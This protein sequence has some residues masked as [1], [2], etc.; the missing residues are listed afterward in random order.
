M[1]MIMFDFSK[2]IGMSFGIDKCKVLNIVRGK[3]QKNGDVELPD[4]KII[5]E[6]EVDEIYKY[7]GV[8]ESIV[9]KHA[10]MKEK[11]IGVFKK[12]L[13]SILRTELN[14]KNLMIAI[15]EY[16]T[17]VL[18]YTFGVLNWTEE[19]IKNIDIHVRKSLNLFRMFP[20]K[21]DIDRLYVPRPMGGRGLASIW[22]CYMCTMVR[23]GHY[24]TGS[25]DQQTFKCAEFDQKSLFSV[26]KKAKKFTDSINF[27]TPTNLH[28]KPLLKQAKLISHKFKEAVQRDRFEKFTQKPQHGVFFR[29][30]DDNALDQKKSMSWLNNC[31]MS[32]Q[33]EGYICAMQELAIFT[34]WH[35]RHILKN[36]KSDTCRICGKESETTFHLLAG[37]DVLA[38]KQY[39]D[40]HN[41]V[42]KYIHHCICR[43]YNFQTEKKWHLHRP[44]EVI[45]DRKVEIIWDMVL[46]TDRN[47]G[48]NRPDIVIRDKSEKV[49]Y[50]I[51]VSCPSDVNVTS[52]E[53]EK[54]SKY[55]G[56]RVEL[57]KMWNCECIVVPIVVGG[58]GALSDK[59]VQYLNMIPA[60][61]SADL[62][63]KITLLGSETIMRSCLS[64]K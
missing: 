16:A 7:L 42:A 60:E 13:K 36:A 2:S 6:M 59:F 53:N 44:A 5:K 49:T 28:E 24:L 17:P 32:P 61:I 55:S 27:Q 1:I 3:Y 37:C 30:L 52:K 21:S 40:R 15:G 56:L 25:T 31:H 63:Q 18:S 26:T 19:E 14:A 41:N 33:S 9:I 58:L 39:L 29:Q 10:E 47:V 64:R 4:G 35:E 46:T 48:A 23:I 45:M 8:V 11:T 57:A 50:I 62:C 20:I 43:A 34:R 54:L 22:D 12:R 38:K 51:D